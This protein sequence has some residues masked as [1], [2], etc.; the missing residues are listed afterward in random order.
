MTVY[1]FWNDSG[2]WVEDHNESDVESNSTVY[3]NFT[4]ADETG[5]R[6]HWMV[7]ANDSIGN[8]TKIFDF[9][10]RYRTSS[11]TGITNESEDSDGDGLSD[12]QERIIGTDPLL[13][14]TD[15]DG[16]TDYEEFL[17]GSDPLDYRSIPNKFSWDFFGIPC[18]LW[19]VVMVLLILLFLILIGKRRKKK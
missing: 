12:E 3:W 10:T 18:L 9:R 4:D 13:S 6:Y 14:D 11:L 7:I 2:T 5:V 17:A 16:Y 15:F 19:I 8:T 1:F